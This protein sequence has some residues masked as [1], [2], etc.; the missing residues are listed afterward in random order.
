MQVV[1]KGSKQGN[2][3]ARAGNEGKRKG[4]GKPKMQVKKVINK[5]KQWEEQ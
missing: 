1:K 4:D 2:D 3:V 5:E